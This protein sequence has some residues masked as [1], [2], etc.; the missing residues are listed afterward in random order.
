MK[1]LLF[2][3]VCKIV[4]KA[5]VASAFTKVF[6]MTKKYCVTSLKN[7]RIMHKYI[8]WTLW[9]IWFYV[10][11]F[12]VIVIFSPL[13]II[14]LSIEKLY[15]FFMKLAHIWALVVF[16][17][18]GFRYDKKQ[19]QKIDGN[20]SYIFVANHTSMMDIML[21]LILIRNPFVFI[22]KKELGKLPI[23]G[24]FYK[25][26]CILVDRSNAQSRRE[27][28]QKAQE[29]L[30]KGLSIC[31]FPEGGVPDTEVVLDNFKDGAFRLAIDFQIPIV[32]MTFVGLKQG[33]SYNFFSGKPMKI[34][35]YMHSLFE[36]KG[37]EMK[38]KNQLKE[39]V[40]QAILSRLE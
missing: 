27:S 31:I 30:T 8:F 34:D 25:R 18:M 37:M 29:K 2:F 9:R 4:N 22:G 32:A 36:T 35:V 13:L 20:Q 24:F 12:V 7:N 11:I 26:A 6:V 28:I 10:L 40:Y 1:N 15:P 39:E 5:E 38:D 3:V 17:G 23:F 19:W 16:Y 21:M 33:F 14:S